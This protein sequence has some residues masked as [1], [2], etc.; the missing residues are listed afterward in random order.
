MIE[1]DQPIPETPQGLRPAFAKWL[2]AASKRPSRIILIIDALNQLEDRDGAPDLVW[3]PEVLPNRVCL[4]VS[5][6]PG[7]PLSEL[8]RRGWPTLPVSPLDPGERRR[9]IVEYLGQYTK[10]LRTERME[11]IAAADQ[12]A[13]PLYL[14]ALLEELRVWGVHERLDERIEHYLGA[15]TVPDLYERILGRYETDYERDRP[16]LVR[17]AMSLLWAARRG[18]SE[19]ELL[20]LLGENGQ[21]LPH[22][23]WSPLFLAAERSLV[24]RSGL[25]GFFHTYLRQA[26][27]NRYLPDA[28]DR[29][30]VHLRLADY[31]DRA[32][33]GLRK[34]EELP[35]QLV[36]S[37]KFDRLYDLLRDLE[38]FRAASVADLDQL[39][40]SWSILEHEIMRGFRMADA[41]RPVINDPPAHLDVAN[42]IGGLLN[43]TGHWEDYA[44]L[45]RGL[46]DHYRR[47]GNR[48]RL[49][50]ALGNQASLLIR[51]GAF[52]EA[53]L[54]LAEQQKILE[55]TVN[56][57]AMEVWLGTMAMLM[58]ERGDLSEAWTALGGQEAIL[59]EL[60]D[61]D[62]LAGCLIQKSF[63]P[64]SRGQYLEALTL[65]QEAMRLAQENDD[66]VGRQAILGEMAVNHLAMGEEGRALK[67]LEEQ[68]DLCRQLGDLESLAGSFGNQGNIYLAR[69]DQQTAHALYSGM[70]QLGKKIGHG[71]VEHVGRS[72]R[73][74]VFFQV[75]QLK[76]AA[77][78]LEGIPEFFRTTGMK[79]P[80][81]RALLLEGNLFLADG[82]P[83]SAV[84]SFSEAV[85]V[86]SRVSTPL[87]VA[88]LLLS[89]ATK[90]L[91]PPKQA[92]RMDGVFTLEEY[93]Q[94][95]SWFDRSREQAEK[96]I[97]FLKRAT[98]FN[99]A[100]AETHHL[101]G[102]ALEKLGRNEEAL[103]NYRQA[104][105]LRPGWTDAEV[106]LAE[107]L[108]KGEVKDE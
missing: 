41:Y 45:C 48:N 6:L 103:S 5:T 62:R 108:M 68:A 35:W 7:R 63:I 28:G 17:E 84:K 11:R 24:N 53:A 19:V 4:V 85:E 33:L 3:L 56:P 89:V 13:N 54:L 14:R 12:A 10:Q 51:K 87:Q 26:V 67:L 73:A 86:C 58:Y 18:L 95:V 47:T 76:R 29:D 71:R 70:E 93:E 75:G 39:K 55:Q 49:S 69:G 52:N 105:A 59:R 9:L 66:L 61:T 20:D 27:Q 31:F 65:L 8:E 96:A 74:Q 91:S 88:G 79:D 30:T 57:R 36:R 50:L 102:I 72:G 81:W 83:D 92:G 101:L 42:A 23:L 77:Q 2:H 37:W 16:G 64:H 78:L 15:K 60:G 82:N 43:V 44:Q 80:L 25:L 100:S 22:S 38:F 90:L 46:I 98:L 32:E 94:A 107:L 34:V 106:R 99:P 40:Q 21:P 97:E 1:A 104:L